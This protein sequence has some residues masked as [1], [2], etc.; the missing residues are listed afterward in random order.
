MNLIAKAIDK[1]TNSSRDT[2]I[3]SSV[4]DIEFNSKN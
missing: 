3:N 1:I 4:D 2:Q